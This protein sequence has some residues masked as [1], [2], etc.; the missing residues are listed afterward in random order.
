MDEP[1]DKPCPVCG[2]VSGG[3]AFLAREM[4]FGLREEFEYRC[5]N[6]CGS[7]W[8]P[9]PPHELDR[10]YG[11]DYYSMDQKHRV[12]QSLLHSTAYRVLATLPANLVD[13]LCL[14][15][16]VRPSFVH[17]IAGAKIGINDRIADVGSGEGALLRRMARCGF[18]NL[19]GIDPFI[20][21]GRIEGPIRFYKS[22]LANI[23]ITFDVI[24]FNHS[25]EHINEPR[26]ELEIARERLSASGTVIV[27][28][29][30]VNT[31]WE[32]YGPNW[33]GLDPPRH[34]F[35]PTVE[36]F[37]RM[38]RDAGFKV[39]RT[40]FDST[41]LQFWGSERY[42]QDVALTAPE[43]SLT[44]TLEA[45]ERTQMRSWK[46]QARYLNRHRRGDTAGFHLIRA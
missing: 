5:C 15:F 33:V 43:E 46:R 1:R 32:R 20:A 2:S 31:S 6:N 8:L 35:V 37:N 16:D 13:H 14:R 12:H 34:S 29:P 28:L 44:A 25:L 26:R 21:D 7:L 23:D 40:F 11:N 3:R 41:A 42:R 27:R 39:N 10:F 36:G 38:A 18:R 19:T 45:R 9:S 24:M 17:S 4:M 22:T 30:I